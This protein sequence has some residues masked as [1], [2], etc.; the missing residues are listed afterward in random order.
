[1][2][3]E[4][5]QE[6]VYEIGPRGDAKVSQ[7]ISLINNFSNIYPQEYHLQINDIKIKNITATDFVGSIVKEII[8]S[9]DKTTIKLRFNQEKIGKGKVTDFKITYYLPQ[10][11]VR[12][13]QIWEMVIPNLDNI[14]EIDSLILKIKAPTSFSNLA[15][16]SISP[17]SQ[18]EIEKYQ[19]ISYQKSKLGKKPLVLAFGDF[20]I[21]DFSLNFFLNNQEIKT[22]KVEVPIPP[23]TAYQSVFLTSIDP[24][25]SRIKLD[26]DYNWLAEYLLS[27]GETKTITVRGQAK[28]FSQAN[29]QTFTNASQFQNTGLYLKEDLYWET[30]SSLIKNLA[31][32]YNTPLKIYNFVTNVLEYDYE[33][34]NKP[35]RVGALKAYQQKKGVCTEFSDLF[36]ALARSAGIP[37]RELEGFAFTNNQKLTLLAASSDV[38][39]SWVE[40]W[41]SGKKLWIPADPTWSKTTNGIDF[42]DN[43][44]LGHFVFVI[45]G[46]SSTK[47]APPGF[48]KTNYQQKNVDVQFANKLLPLPKGELSVKLEN[49]Q[50]NLKLIIKNESLAPAYNVQVALM[51][52]RKKK[53]EK[54]EIVLMPPLGEEGIE[55][56]RPNIITRIFTKP[57]YHLQI[58]DSLFEVDYSKSKLNF[59]SFFANL[60]KR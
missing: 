49:L 48:Y 16:S 19:L 11:A 47:P 39:H 18:E 12:R 14:E 59:L 26:N 41:D 28:I 27:P 30:N 45:H 35:E 50:D 43:F 54:R 31:R 17:S 2:E 6:I 52:W 34:L 53:L 60:L 42:I 24:P 1:L 51:G 33:N 15:Y 25:P 36:V 4:T 5:K 10:F 38:L 9:L 37:A 32:Q 7:E 46:Q 3:F 23:D 55:I 8:E 20:Q 40:Y 57:V 29:N 58:N 22:T 21:F 56:S 13:G 44:D